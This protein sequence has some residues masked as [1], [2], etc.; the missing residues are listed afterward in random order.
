MMTPTP[1]P[2]ARP[3]LQCWVVVGGFG[4][5]IIKHMGSGEPT[6]GEGKRERVMAQA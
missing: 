5:A 2:A 6:A 4:D 3:K 1:T